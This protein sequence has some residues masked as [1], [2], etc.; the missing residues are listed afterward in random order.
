MPTEEGK[1]GRSFFMNLATTYPAQHSALAR[2]FDR[3][4]NA[5]GRR[6]NVERINRYL[7]LHAAESATAKT[8]GRVRSTRK[9]RPKA[10]PSKKKRTVRKK[11][12]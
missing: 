7:K 2:E 10:N 11:S 12:R 3:I 5:A 1:V 6:E 8:A 9:S 4:L